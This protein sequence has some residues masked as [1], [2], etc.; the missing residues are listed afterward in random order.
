MCADLT[1]RLVVKAN[2]MSARKM[3]IDTQ[4][5]KSFSTLLFMLASTD[6]TE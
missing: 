3:I 1:I 6:H 5:S 4:F 2:S